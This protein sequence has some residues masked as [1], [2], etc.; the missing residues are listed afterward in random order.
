MSKSRKKLQGGEKFDALLSKL[1]HVPKKDVD[2][3][4]AAWKKARAAKKKQ[5]PETPG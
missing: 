1:A 3:V 5:K 2:R 4:S